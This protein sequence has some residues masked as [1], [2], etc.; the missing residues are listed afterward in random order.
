MNNFINFN[1]NPDNFYIYS[2]V[3]SASQASD[4]KY[5]LDSQEE[6]CEKY[7]KETY[8]LTSENIVEKVNYYCDVGSSY[9][10]PKS[11]HQL[12]LMTKQILPN[13]LILISEISRLGRNVRQVINL[14]KNFED[15]NCWIISVSEGLCFNKS[16]LM[17]KQFYQKTIDAERES[18]LI[19][20]RTKNAYEVIKKSGGYVGNSPYGKK[21]VKINGITKLV[22][23]NEEIEIIKIVV[24][25][26][27]EFGLYDIVANK[28]YDNNIKKRN[29][30]WTRFSVYSIIK[31][32]GGIKTT[33]QELANKISKLKL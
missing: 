18:D 8:K 26:Y 14:L 15:K 20:I 32:F 4:N 33:Y 11:L 23:N 5:G 1:L 7:L 27:R 6:F 25:L 29:L 30:N 19:S 2:R 24:G 17:N 9:S 13:S 31:K 28:L 22:D 16:K 21:K 3:S 12:N 10:N